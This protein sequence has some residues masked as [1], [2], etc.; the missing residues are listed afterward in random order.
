MKP[1]EQGEDITV[2]VTFLTV[3]NEHTNHCD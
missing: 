3:K 2:V 1:D